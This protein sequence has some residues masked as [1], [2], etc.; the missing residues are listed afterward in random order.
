[1]RRTGMGRRATGRLA[2][3]SA[4]CALLAQDYGGEPSTNRVLGA[5]GRAAGMWETNK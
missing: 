3:E 1:M 4:D 2:R 5:E